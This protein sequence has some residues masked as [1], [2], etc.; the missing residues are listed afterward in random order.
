MP[1]H[2]LWDVHGQ[3]VLPVVLHL[4]QLVHARQVPPLGERNLDNINIISQ[5]AQNL[6]SWFLLFY[7]M[8]EWRP[9]LWNTS[10]EIVL[11]KQVLMRR[12]T[13]M[14]RML[15]SIKQLGIL[16][17][18]LVKH[19]WTIFEALILNNFFVWKFLGSFLTFQVYSS[20]CNI[21]ENKLN[22]YLYQL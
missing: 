20:F 4:L 13:Y 12:Q 9:G 8:Q 11:V 6:C 14:L 1:D 18:C 7:K 3:Q 10:L 16:S 2:G 19:L 17:K 22:Y 21:I 5:P 15:Q